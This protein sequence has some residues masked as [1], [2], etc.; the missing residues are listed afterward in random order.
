MFRVEAFSGVV[1]ATLPR[2]APSPYAT[3]QQRVAAASLTPCAPWQ[4]RLLYRCSAD[5]A[6]VA[7]CLND[8]LCARVPETAV[9]V[10]MT[11][12]ADTH[13]QTNFAGAMHSPH[14]CS[15]ATTITISS[16]VSATSS[17]ERQTLLCAWPEQRRA[18]RFPIRHLN[19]W[20]RGHLTREGA[21]YVRAGFKVQIP[22][23]WSEAL[24]AAPL[25]A[26]SPASDPRPWCRARDA[27]GR[28]WAVSACH[29]YIEE[30]AGLSGEGA[31]SATQNPV[32]RPLHRTNKLD[33]KYT[34]RLQFLPG[35]QL[36]LNY[37]DHGL[38]Y[39]WDVRGPDARRKPRFLCK[40]AYPNHKK[41][42]GRYVSE[43]SPDGRW[44]AVGPVTQVRDEQPGALRVIALAQGK[45]VDGKCLWL[46]DEHRIRHLA[47]SQE[48]GVVIGLCDASVRHLF[49]YA[50]NVCD[51][52]AGMGI[53]PRS[54]VPIP[55]VDARGITSMRMTVTPDD[56]RVM[57]SVLKWDRLVVLVVGFRDRGDLR[58]DDAATPLS[59]VATQ[60]SID[61]V[62]W[63][64]K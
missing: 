26:E 60:T 38:L 14:M 7:L 46:D 20:H 15:N 6:L 18:V 27:V 24:Q 1:M 16:A 13:W 37:R 55:R 49:V 32:P 28:W 53:V 35:P 54:I 3:L 33:F 23:Y 48:G 31:A 59:S 51:A 50:W 43:A 9:L 19:H 62:A 17:S 12:P 64:E 61:K 58:K 45:Q 47:W 11:T 34:V 41:Q 63:T 22:R 4:I 39:V 2:S 10:T 29:R 44:V 21:Y 30:V 56:C 42:H 52:D 57:I 36:L 5:G 8:D 25:L 40:R